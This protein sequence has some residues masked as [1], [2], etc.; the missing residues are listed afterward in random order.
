MNRQTT[1]E[2]LNELLI[3]EITDDELKELLRRLGEIEFAWNPKTT[4]RDVAEATSADPVLLGRLLADIRKED[5]EERFGLR[6]EDHEDRLERIEEEQRQTRR[7]LSLSSLTRTKTIHQR[8]AQPTIEVISQ[9]EDPEE[10]FESTVSKQMR[11]FCYA[12]VACFAFAFIVFLA[13]TVVTALTSGQPN[14]LPPGW[15]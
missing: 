15:H 5:W 12:V 1:Q 10:Y 3:Q 2:Q 6:V 13:V 11:Y 8:V 4:I 7:L 14:G 9:V